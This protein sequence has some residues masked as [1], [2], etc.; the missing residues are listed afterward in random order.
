MR[1]VL[2]YSVCTKC[3][4]ISR[5]RAEGIV[6][7]KLYER[8][9]LWPHHVSAKHPQRGKASYAAQFSPFAALAGYDGIVRETERY[10][11]Q[12]PE[13]DD[14]EKMRIDF[15]LRIIIEH[16]NEEKEISVTYF[17]PDKTKPGGSAVTVRGVLRKFEPQKGTLVFADGA[18]VPANDII[19]I[20]AEIINRCLFNGI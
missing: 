19:S 15:G 13:L 8:I 17:V 11:E 20:D 1:Y 10:T 12:R 9:I 4:K 2:W 7:E 18:E 14:S 6:T 3:D 5:I 16:I